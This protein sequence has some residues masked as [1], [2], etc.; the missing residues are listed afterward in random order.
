MADEGCGLA[1]EILKTQETQ[2]SRVPIPS[3]LNASKTPAS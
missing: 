2:G 3:S 1:V